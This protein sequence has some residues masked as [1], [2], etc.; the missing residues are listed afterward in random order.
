V[1]AVAWLGLRSKRRW[2]LVLQV[3]GHGVA[4]LYGDRGC[5]GMWARASCGGGR[6]CRCQ[7]KRESEPGSSSRSGKTPTGGSRLS[8]REEGRREVRAGWL[9]RGR[10]KQLGQLGRAGGREGKEERPT[11]LGPR[12]R[13]RER[14][15][16]KREWAGPKGKKREKNCIQMHL[17]LNLKFKFKWKTNN[18]TMQWH[19]MHK[20]YISLYF[21]LG[22]SKL[23]LIHSKCSKIK[24]I[25]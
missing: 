15:K 9:G 24:I 2:L 4:V 16:R 5:L 12:G 7:T 13:K 19:E 23:L 25:E 21:F 8:S 14:G 6:P 22:S 10:R 3:L 11:G 17:I 1:K 18:K 20:T